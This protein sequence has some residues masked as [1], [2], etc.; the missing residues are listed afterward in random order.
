V[1]E[2]GDGAA[3]RRLRAAFDHVQV[4]V[5]DLEAAARRL[6]DEHGLVAVPGGRHPGRGTANM[7]VPLGDSYLELIAVVDRDEAAARPTSVRVARAVAEGRTFPVWSARVDDLDGARAVLAARGLELPDATDGRRR[8][9]DGVELRWRMQELVPDARFS[10]L[11][12]LIEWALPP[13]LY[14]GAMPARHARRMRG[15]AEVRLSDPEPA[16]CE[17]LLAS[18]LAG[19]LAYTVERGPSGV[20][21][22]V[23]DTED[24][25]LALR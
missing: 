19:G 7:I 24:G 22:V 8:R 1:T 15:V 20:S 18:L 10:P 9:P 2:G 21:A 4:A 5:P 17:P 16:G 12:F 14:P 11:P 3:A 13:E 23:L 25:P 6:L